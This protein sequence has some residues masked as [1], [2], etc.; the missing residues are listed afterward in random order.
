MKHLRSFEE[1]QFAKLAESEIQIEQHWLDLFEKVFTVDIVGEEDGMYIIRI[2]GQEYGYK[3]KKGGRM[4]DMIKGFE[5][6]HKHNKGRA[7]AWL[8]KNSD[9]VKGSKKKNES[10]DFMDELFE[11]ETSQYE[12]PK[13]LVLPQGEADD[14]GPDKIISY[15]EGLHGKKS[16]YFK[17]G[18]RSANP[19]VNKKG[20]K[21]NADD[22]DN[23][24]KD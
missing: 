14:Q 10:Y 6:L 3:P 24:Q 16:T 11:K 21:H 7:L 12:P 22:A 20:E 17:P 1:F 23:K 4:K 2:S 18:V 9:L 19:P 8:K 15:I 13:Y 5:K